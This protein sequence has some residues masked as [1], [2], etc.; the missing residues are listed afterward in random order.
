[1]PEDTQSPLSCAN[2]LRKHPAPW[3]QHTLVGSNVIV[4]VDASG[5]EVPMFTFLH[6]T[7]QVVQ[8]H[9]NMRAK[10]AEPV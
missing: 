7:L 9:S 1:M 3:S 8:A 5:Q 4:V 6:F 2:I 10:A